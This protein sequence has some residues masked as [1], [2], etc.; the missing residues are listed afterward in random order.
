VPLKGWPLTVSLIELED[1]LCRDLL[2]ISGDEA[3]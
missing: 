3:L 1:F 2:S